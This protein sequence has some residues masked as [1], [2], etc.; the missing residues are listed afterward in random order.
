MKA[1]LKIL[2]S[3]KEVVE[4]EAK[5]NIFEE[6]LNG[7]EYIQRPEDAH[8]QPTQRER[9]EAFVREQSLH[10]PVQNINADVVGKVL[11]PL[12]PVYQTDQSCGKCELLGDVTNVYSSL[13][14]S[15]MKKELSLS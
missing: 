4:A 9:T 14:K 2:K 8:V 12:A 11:N 5:L 3:K 13:T 15:I 10:T 1:K 6:S 7:D